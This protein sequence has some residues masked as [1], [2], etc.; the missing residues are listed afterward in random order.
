[1]LGNLSY[2]IFQALTTFT[3]AFSIVLKILEY[4]YSFFSLI[5]EEIQFLLSFFIYI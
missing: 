5:L 4:F 1:M 3:L 2:K